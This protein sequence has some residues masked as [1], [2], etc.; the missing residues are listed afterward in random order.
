MGITKSI[1]KRIKRLGS[2]LRDRLDSWKGEKLRESLA[3]F[4]KAYE[5]LTRRRF[6]QRE[7]IPQVVDPDFEGDLATI[8]DQLREKGFAICRGWFDEQWVQT[9]RAEMDG[10]ET[11]WHQ[12]FQDKTKRANVDDPESKGTFICG[13]YEQ[14]KRLRVNFFQGQAEAAPSAIAGLLTDPRLVEIASRYFDSDTESSYVLA[15]RLE[16]APQ[17]DRWHVDRI[18]DQLKAMVLLTDVEQEQGP[19]RYKSQ[20]HRV[21]EG[22]SEV[23][24]RVFKNGVDEAYPDNELVDSMAGEVVYGCGKAGDCI[25]FDTLGIHSGTQCTA[26]FRQAF[27][28]TFAGPTHK[29]KQ[30]QRWTNQDW[31]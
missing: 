13:N 14:N 27:V 22:M 1:S 25:I 30:L 7:R 11:K 16:P 24:H 29:T 20:T 12:I 31:I 15:E 8:T 23:Y 28:A 3:R 19:L 10:L 26:G 4:E 2:K 9:A 6:E 17:G 5:L 18:V 21:P